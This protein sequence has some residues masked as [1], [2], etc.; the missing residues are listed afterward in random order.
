MDVYARDMCCMQ[1]WRR[2]ARGSDGSCVMV[3]KRYVIK[4]IMVCKRYMMYVLGGEKFWVETM[5][6]GGVDGRL[7]EI[8]LTNDDSMLKVH[9]YIYIT[10]NNVYG[11]I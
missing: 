6:C 4:L 11:K 3:R 5:L 8:R 7:W 2:L 10:Q 9:I 1:G